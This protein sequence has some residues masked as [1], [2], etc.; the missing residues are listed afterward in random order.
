MKRLSVLLAIIMLIASTSLVSA[1]NWKDGTYEAWSDASDKSMNYAKVFIKDGKITGV[2]LREYNNYLVEK[3]YASYP[4]Q[5][6]REALRTHAPKYVAAQGADVDLVTSATGSTTGWNQAVE[7]ALLKADPNYNPGKTYFDGTF[8]GRSETGDRNYYEV[9][10]VTIKDDKIVDMK[11][12]RVSMEPTELKIVELEDYPWPLLGPA[13]EQ[14]KENAIKAAP[15]EADLVTGA[16]GSSKMW[17]NAV[18]DAL[19][20]ARIR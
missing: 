18:L 19:D 17:D 3:D 16:T 1:A 4:F 5:L 12:Q 2:I 20:R 9:V 15:G 11:F 14:Y 13:R 10:W 8:M 6:Y 7:R